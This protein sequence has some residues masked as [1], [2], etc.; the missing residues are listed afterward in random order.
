MQEQD[1]KKFV[2]SM[3]VDDIFM[4]TYGILLREALLKKK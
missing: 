4:V 3:T 2:V 1:F